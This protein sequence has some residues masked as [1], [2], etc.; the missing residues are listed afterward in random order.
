MNEGCTSD[1]PSSPS[2]LSCLR[3]A[4]LPPLAS[5]R[6]SRPGLPNQLIRAAKAA[7]KHTYFYQKSCLLPRFFTAFRNF[8]IFYLLSV[9]K[10]FPSHHLAQSLA[11]ARSFTIEKQLQSSNFLTNFA[12]FVKNFLTFLALFSHLIKLPRC[13]RGPQNSSFNCK[14]LQTD[15]AFSAIIYIDKKIER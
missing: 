4:T 5:P 10:R 14:K 11:L 6:F 8:Q 7:A 15:R 12:A 3:R 1:F 9:E 2:K 13:R